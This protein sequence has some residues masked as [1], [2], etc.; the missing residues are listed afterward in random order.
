MTVRVA[1][2][3][4]ALAA[5]GGCGSSRDR[6]GA[7]SASSPPAG[8]AAALL[9]A[10]REIPVIHPFSDGEESPSVAPA[11]RPVVAIERFEPK[12][13]TAGG[14]LQVR[15]QGT[16]PRGLPLRLEY[17]A[18][19]G[20]AWQPLVNNPLTLPTPIPGS[21]TLQLRA[22]D[23]AGRESEVLSRS[24]SVSP[25][26]RPALRISKCVPEVPYAG[27]TLEVRLEGY[28]THP[29]TEY[30]YRLAQAEAWQPATAGCVQV[31]NLARGSL[32]LQ[33]RCLDSTGEASD[34]LRRGWDILSPGDVPLDIVAAGI[35]TQEPLIGGMLQVQLSSQ[36]PSPRLEFQYRVAPDPTWR[37]APEGS[38]A[39]GPL[40]P[41]EIVVQFR[42]SDRLHGDNA[43]SHM[44]RLNV[45]KQRFEVVDVRRAEGRLTALI[46]DH[47]RGE[48]H[49][50]GPGDALE[51][52]RLVAVLLQRKQVVFRDPDGKYSYLAIPE[53]VL[54]ELRSQ[55]T[56]T[57]RA[58]SRQAP[59][60]GR[61]ERY[62]GSRPR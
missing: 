28:G 60:R 46:A 13:L 61:S 38:V 54:E 5:L 11:L 53:T 7:S 24:W 34:V 49:S 14:H 41:G 12:T 62:I 30:Q 29:V 45:T 1:M 9:V 20:G 40:K 32:E 2:S 37:G 57:A 15:V 39:V 52:Q 19:D 27:D 31:P 43:T 26:P 36:R 51:D 18:T 59:V 10:S 33:F 22:V 55:S 42:V 56:T 25:K 58:T 16:S 17:R 50:V 6:A 3:L 21:L 48:K 8:A 23:A 44:Y 4:F 35:D 47:Q